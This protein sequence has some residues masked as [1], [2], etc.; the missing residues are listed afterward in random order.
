MRMAQRQAAAA[1]KAPVRVTGF[2][3]TAP[4]DWFATVAHKLNAAAESEAAERETETRALLCLLRDTTNSR[5]VYER[6]KAI[7]GER[8]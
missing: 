4:I 8:S 2:T 7:V 3:P 1:V 5:S 6:C